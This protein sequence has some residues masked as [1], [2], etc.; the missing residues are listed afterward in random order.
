MISRFWGPDNLAVWRPGSPITH[1][2]TSGPTPQSPRP[3]QSPGCPTGSGSHEVAQE[4]CP[5]SQEPLSP[6]SC[7]QREPV[8]FHNVGTGPL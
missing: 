3:L 2:M 4:H 1:P 8:A 5:L 6:H 7:P